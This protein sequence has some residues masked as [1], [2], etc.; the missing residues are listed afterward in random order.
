VDGT[1]T[2]DRPSDDAA[3]RALLGLGTAV[4]QAPWPDVRDRPLLF[5]GEA[6]N[7][8]SE[9]PRAVAYAVLG[10]GELLQA[11]PDDAGARHLV[12]DAADS[13][14]SPATDRARRLAS[15]PI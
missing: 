7:F 11:L 6:A 13:L 5:F 4:A 1:W 15:G 14:P 9:H 2:D 12:S 10:A 3:G 8:R